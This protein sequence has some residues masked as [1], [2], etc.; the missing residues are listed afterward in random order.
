VQYRVVAEEPDFGRDAVSTG[1]ITDFSRDRSA[2]T[3]RVK[4]WESPVKRVCRY[5]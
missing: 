2:L 4:Q 1:K 5:R 3:F